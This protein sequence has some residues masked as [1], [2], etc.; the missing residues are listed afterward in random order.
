M[1]EHV[2]QN[3]YVD[4]VITNSNPISVSNDVKMYRGPRGYSNYELAKQHGFEGTEE[5][6]LESIKGEPGTTNYLDS[7]NKPSIEGVT[8]VDDKTFEDLGAMSLTNLEIEKI[9][10][11]NAL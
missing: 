10:N 5:E 9:I 1:N 11:N 3:N 8:L 7:I 6:Y 4:V 2:V